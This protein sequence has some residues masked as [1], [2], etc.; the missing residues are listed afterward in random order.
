MGS[1]HWVTL[2][3]LA[4]EDSVRLWEGTAPL[5]GR[6]S[7]ERVSLRRV[8]GSLC[9]HGQTQGLESCLLLGVLSK[10]A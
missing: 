6:Q 4:E 9:E 8:V 10:K 1:V 5:V 7:L 2:V 3:T